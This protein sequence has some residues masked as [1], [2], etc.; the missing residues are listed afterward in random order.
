[1][2]LLDVVNLS[3]RDAD[4]FDIDDFKIYCESSTFLPT[5]SCTIRWVIELSF[6]VTRKNILPLGLNFQAGL[7]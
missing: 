4:L 2:Q 1:V 6:R 5:F 3:M 7:R